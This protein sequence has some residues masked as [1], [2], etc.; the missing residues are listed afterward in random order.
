MANFLPKFE[1]ILGESA[2]FVCG[3]EACWADFQLLYGLNYLEEI[4]PGSLVS[5]PYLSALRETL[6]ALPRMVEFFATQ[7]KPL[8]T[9]KYMTEVR[10]AQQPANKP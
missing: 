4:L 2:P 5:Y 10:E 7:A 1:S 3:A 9:A 8:V 6:N